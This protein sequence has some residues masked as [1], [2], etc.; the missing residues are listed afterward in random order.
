VFWQPLSIA[1]EDAALGEAS[2]NFG[3]SPAYVQFHE[4]HHGFGSDTELDRFSDLISL[5]FYMRRYEDLPGYMQAA[6]VD[7]AFQTYYWGTGRLS[8][9]W[10][11]T[12]L[13]SRRASAWLYNRYPEFYG[14]AIEERRAYVA[15]DSGDVPYSYWLDDPDTSGGRLRRWSREYRAKP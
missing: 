2:F 4:M 8:G 7:K 6:V 14:Q 13:A 3:L 11:E 9:R 12:R 1:E 15:D 10:R 5:D